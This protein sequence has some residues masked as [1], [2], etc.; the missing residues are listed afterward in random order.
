MK[1][2]A[3]V[4]SVV[5]LWGTVWANVSGGISN[6]NYRQALYK[7]IDAAVP[8]LK[9][10]KFGKNPI[11]VLPM[12]EDPGNL[13][14]ER[15]RNILTKLGFVSVVG[16]EETEALNRI[17]S[18]IANSEKKEDIF[19]PSTLVKFGKLKNTRLLMRC[20][21]LNFNQNADRTFVEIDLHVVEIATGKRLWGD[22]F[23]YRYYPKK[24]VRGAVKIDAR[25]RV[26]LKKNLAGLKKSLAES[27]V[28]EK[29]GAV[30]KIVVIPVNGDDKGYI[31]DLAIQALSETQYFPERTDIPSISEF[32][33]AVNDKSVDNKIVFYGAL[34]DLQISTPEKKLN[35]DGKWVMSKKITG[36]VQLFIENA[37]NKTVLWSNN[38]F[39]SEADEELLPPE[40]RDYRLYLWIA[41]GVVAVLVLFFVMFLIM[42][43]LFAARNMVR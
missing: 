26:L 14:T 1:K 8:S 42:V 43:K 23:S 19:D 27:G 35:S 15:L 31:T 6:D 9:K 7:A 3:V 38:F 17:Y 36:E 37:E 13:V 21:V 25:L 11:A 40:P 18:E 39:F 2:I 29:M 12:K 10:A 34:R 20:R 33:Y 16:K 30:K 32:R 22:T 24:E 28:M 5:L 41:G 4:F